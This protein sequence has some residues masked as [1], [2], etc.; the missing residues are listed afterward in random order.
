MAYPWLAW[1]LLIPAGNCC[2][3]RNFV[4]CLI[5]SSLKLVR[6]GVFTPLKTE[7]VTNGF[8]SIALPAQI[9]ASC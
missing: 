4:N 7:N 5:L 6:V 8:L 9:R 1:N 2:I 3:F